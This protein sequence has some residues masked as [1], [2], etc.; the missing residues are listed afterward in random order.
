MVKEVLKYNYHIPIE[1][2]Q[3][4]QNSTTARLSKVDLIFYWQWSCRC[5]SRNSS[6]FSLIRAYSSLIWIGNI[7]QIKGGAYKVKKWIVPEKIESSSAENSADEEENEVV[8]AGNFSQN[9][10]VIEIFDSDEEKE[11]LSKSFSCSEKSKELFDDD[12]DHSDAESKSEGEEIGKLTTQW[13]HDFSKLTH[14]RFR[15]IPE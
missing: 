7:L 4:P 10:E 1:D 11:F 15:W 12:H 6:H 9:D 14:F 8:F 3:P 13:F 5:Y 2:L